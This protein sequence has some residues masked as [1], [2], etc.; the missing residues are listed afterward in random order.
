MKTLYESYARS[1]AI[2]GMPIETQW[3]GRSGALTIQNYEK[4]YQAFTGDQRASPPIDFSF[5]GGSNVVT[6][7]TTGNIYTGQENVKISGPQDLTG[8]LNKWTQ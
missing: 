3:Q 4:M 2:G 5:L 1:A 6:P 8:L 7:G